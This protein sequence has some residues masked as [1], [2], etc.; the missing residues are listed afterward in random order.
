MLPFRFDNS[1]TRLSEQFYRHCPP[2]PVIAPTLISFNE[3][4]AA[5]LGLAGEAV[6]PQALAQLFSGNHLPEGAQP[7]ATV[8]AGHQFGHFNPQLGDGRAIL[9]GE[10]LDGV[11]SRRDIQLKGAGRTPYSRGGDGRSPLGPVLREYLISE[12]MHALGVPTTRA[13]AAVTTGEPVY[14]EEALPG[15]I[16]TR[17]AASHIRVGTFEYFAAKGDVASVRLLADHVIDRHYP[18]CLD[19]EQPYR[20]LLDAV[21]RR[22]AALIA[23]WMSIGFIHGVMNTDNML[24]SGETIDYGP[25]A[26]LDTYHPGMVFS[27]IDTGGRY[28]YQMQPAIG[29]WNMARF[30]ETLLPLLGDNEAESL[31]YAT[32]IIRSF[33]GY[34]E[35]AWL[36]KMRSKL[37]LQTEQEGDKAIIEALLAA[38]D[39]C[40]VDFTLFF[41]QLADAVAAPLEADGVRALFFRPALWQ[42]WAAS[43]QA[44]MMQEPLSPSERVAMMRSVNPSVIPRNHRI[45]KA[46][47]KA[48][49]HADFRDFERLLTVLSRPFDNQPDDADWMGP[50]QAGE[51]VCKTFCG[52]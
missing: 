34:Y 7:V 43:W 12:A 15:A 40:D 49:E 20:D 39:A 44:R 18:Q 24:V 42:N 11:G 31:Q 19:G 16:L 3:A 4:L 14:R 38:M 8:Y 6:N 32:G 52:T 33:S 48:T 10:V 36:T 25:C 23:H 27:S 46:I 1:Y 50:P 51:R 21:V 13:L 41:R 37:G 26:F 5:E 30:A 29:Q 17:V 2:V 35:T 28:A 22:Q 47:D 9:L 45:E